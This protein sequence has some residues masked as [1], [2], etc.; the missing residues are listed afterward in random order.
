MGIPVLIIGKSGS[1]KSSSLR[2]FGPGDIEIINVLSKPLPFKNSFKVHNT[3]DYKEVSQIIKESP[4]KSIV[5]DDAGYLITNMFMRGHSITGKGNDIYAFY[6]QM[7]DH[8]WKLINYIKKIDE[9]KIVYF[10]MHEDADEFGGIK[11]KTIGKLL[12]EKVCIEGMFT[13]VLRSL[14]TESGYRFLTATNG[15]DVT[16]TPIGMFETTEI[17]ND[18]KFVDKTIREYYEL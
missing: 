12:D 6:N 3:D 7:A 16:K 5:V 13:I 17:D 18:L 4:L 14:R 15:L 9:T 10:T 11:P 8:F 2:N 1:G